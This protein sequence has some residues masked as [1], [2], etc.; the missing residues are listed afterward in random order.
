MQRRGIENTVQV[1]FLSG[2][3]D[4]KRETPPPRTAILGWMD[5]QVNAGLR[6]TP[7]SLTGANPGNDE[8]A[9]SFKAFAHK[10]ENQQS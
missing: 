5:R 6:F 7:S 9:S 2:L 3:A 8:R 4:Q 1:P 10:D